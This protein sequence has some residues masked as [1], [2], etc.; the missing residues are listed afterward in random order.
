M[1]TDNDSLTNRPAVD[2]VAA[3]LGN[4][5]LRALICQSSVA[6]FYDA[7]QLDLGNRRVVLKV[8]SGDER[9]I[10]WFRQETLRTARLNHPNIIQIYQLGQV[11]E[12]HFCAMQFLEGRSLKLIIAEQG[13]FTPIRALAIIKQIAAALDHA[14]SL[15][16]IHTDIKP[17]K[18]L[19]D[20]SNHTTLI[21]FNM[22][23]PV[24]NPRYMAPEQVTRDSPPD[25]YTDIYGFGLTVF[26]IL[27]GRHPYDNLPPKDMI[28]R[29]AVGPPP[30]LRSL[31]A[32]IPAAADSVLQRAMARRRED[33]FSSAG[34]F[35]DALAR[36][37]FLR[38]DHS[39]KP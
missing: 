13:A 25:N 8:V 10:D 33:R 2:G 6:A 9:T 39:I 29:I 16:V 31:N 22:R 32:N 11:G 37:F 23:P 12:R 38:S 19:L 5:R 4:Y 3:I 20:Q 18:I 34:E 26:E 1:I 17:W 24:G 35:A 30:S 14:H 15:G 28:V 36:S 7:E 27:A 21:G